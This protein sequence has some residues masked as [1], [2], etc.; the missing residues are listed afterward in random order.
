MVR[1]SSPGGSSSW[2]SNNYSVWLSS[3][4]CGTGVK[5]AVYD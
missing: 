1:R 4:E 5:S 3:L 2:S